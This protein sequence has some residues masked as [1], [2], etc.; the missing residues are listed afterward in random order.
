LKPKGVTP[1]KD[2]RPKQV[3]KLL[4]HFYYFVPTFSYYFKK[5]FDNPFMTATIELLAIQQTERTEMLVD[6]RKT[7]VAPKPSSKMMVESAQE[8]M[9]VRNEI[10]ELEAK[11]KELTSLLEAEFGK[12]AENN[13]STYVELIHRGISFAKLD[14][15]TRTGIDKD[16]LASEFPEAFEACQSKTT[17]SVVKL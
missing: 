17:Y 1:S 12:N 11:K 3:S 4:I 14:W 7:T 15:V 10:R 16:K 2:L 6:E 5:G 8:L 13:T 9:R